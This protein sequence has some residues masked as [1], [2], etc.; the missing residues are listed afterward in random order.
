MKYKPSI[1]LPVFR[2]DDAMPVSDTPALSVMTAKSKFYKYEPSSWEADDMREEA[3][4]I[5]DTLNRKLETLLLE[6][7]AKQ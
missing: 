7:G 4:I 5:A 2:V 6:M 1:I 3:Q